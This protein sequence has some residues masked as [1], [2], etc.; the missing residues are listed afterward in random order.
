[1][2][3]FLAGFA[4]VA[5]IGAMAIV[6]WWRGVR[7]PTVLRT[8]LEDALKHLFEQEY[9]GRRASLSS[10]AGALALGDSAVLALVTRMQQQGLLTARGQEFDL[11]PDGQRMA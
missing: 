2:T 8:R 11:T 5:V 10:L 9:R 4:A 7:R 1:M 6:W 3:G